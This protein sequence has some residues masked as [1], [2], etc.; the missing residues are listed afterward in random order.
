MYFVKNKITN[1][2]HPKVESFLSVRHEYFQ[3]YSAEKI[4]VSWVI[5]QH[6]PQRRPV[7]GEK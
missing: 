1:H 5:P 6:D 3:L 4:C 7:H 2:L